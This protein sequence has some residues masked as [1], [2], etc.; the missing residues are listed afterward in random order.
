MAGAGSR[1]GHAHGAS[2]ETGS[3]PINDS[4]VHPGDL[5]ATIYPAVGIDPA[6]IAYNHLNQP[7]ELVKGDVVHSLF[8]DEA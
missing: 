1:R 7:R 8:Q 6:T 5:L 2:D 3:A 4:G